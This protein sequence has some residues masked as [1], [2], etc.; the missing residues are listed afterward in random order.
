MLCR[1][2]LLVY[3]FSKTLKR[4]NDIW[5]NVKLYFFLIP[6]FIDGPF[7]LFKVN[8]FISKPTTIIKS[9]E[10]PPSTITRPTITKSTPS[11]EQNQNSIS[12]LNHNRTSFST[13]QSL[14]PIRS[15]LVRTSL[16]LHY[17]YTPVQGFPNFRSHV[18]SLSTKCN[19]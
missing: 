8:Y 3:I 4:L 6:S 5:I 18:A 15:A 14:A 9:I 13:Y 7:F 11:L 1:L 17:Q 2:T 12:A 10:L 16:T 19:P